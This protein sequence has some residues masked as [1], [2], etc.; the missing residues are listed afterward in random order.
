MVSAEG[1]SFEFRWVG[2]QPGPRRSVA[3]R[4]LSSQQPLHTLHSPAAA[5]LGPAS[6]PLPHPHARAGRP[7]HARARW[8]RGCLRWRARCGAR[9]PPP[10]RRASSST[11]RRRAPAGLPTAWAWSRWRARRW[12]AAGVVWRGRWKGRLC[13]NGAG[14]AA[15]AELHTF[16]AQLAKG[17]R[18]A[19]PGLAAAAAAAAHN[20]TPPLR[21]VWW[22]WETEDVF[23]RVR[24]GNKHA[25]KELGAKLTGQLQELTSMVRVPPPPSSPA[26]TPCRLNTTHADA[27]QARIE[28][29]TQPPC[30]CR[31]AASW[32]ARCGARST[33]W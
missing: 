5:S 15:V 28:S 31:C 27:K 30:P 6:H 3:C 17:C 32:A 20:Q 1:E 24:Q 9:W 33:R 21:Q 2:L 14:S 29:P 10:P 13:C 25:M 8:R 18:H 16:R 4:R 22:T 23:R 11:R 26:T 7:C 12:A 19:G